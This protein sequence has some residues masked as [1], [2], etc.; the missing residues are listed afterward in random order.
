M[1]AA[2]Y[3]AILTCGW[4]GEPVCDPQPTQWETYYVV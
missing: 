4:P 3:F 2:F 1:I